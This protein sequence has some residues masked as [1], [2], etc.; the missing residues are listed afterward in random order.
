VECTMYHTHPLNPH[1]PTVGTKNVSFWGKVTVN[2]CVLK[3]ATVW[4]HF[5]YILTYFLIK[6]ISFIQV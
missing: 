6:K 4:G 5:K 1:S 2:K 3:S